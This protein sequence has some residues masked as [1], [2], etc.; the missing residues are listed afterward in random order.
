[1]K[2]LVQATSGPGFASKEDGVQL[3]REHVL[4]TFDMLLSW[5]ADG[6]IMGGLPVG[7]RAMA[8]VVEAT[9]NDALDAMLREIPLWGLLEWV[10]TPLTGFAE[11]REIDR[12][13]VKSVS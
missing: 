10:V 7:D 3:L 6:K 13:A 12:D 5:E 9:S 8:F 1:M 2:Y 4:P 11:R